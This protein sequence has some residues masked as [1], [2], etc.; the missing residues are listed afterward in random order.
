MRKRIIFVIFA[1]SLPVLGFT[2]GAVGHRTIAYI[3]E[4]YLTA[5]T[6]QKI[7]AIL[8]KN[9]D[10]NLAYISTWADDVRN[11]P[12]YSDTGFWHFINLP[13]RKDITKNNVMRYCYYNNCIVSQINKE[14]NELKNKNTDKKTQYED[15]KFLVHFIGDLHMPLHCSNDSDSGGNKKIVRLYE[16]AEDSYGNTISLHA[17]W[18]CIIEY[19][20]I[21]NPRN[22]ASY[23]EKS[24]TPKN[25]EPWAYGTIEDWAFESY[26]IAKYKIYA[27]FP[28]AGAT[29]K[30]VSLNKN[31]YS[32][33]RP[34]A[35]EQIK[36]AGIR[37][38]KVLNEIFGR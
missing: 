20:P 4:D 7:N 36:K 32:R 27:D 5:K 6:K 8:V 21:E 31:Y 38:A 17:L 29:F 11:Q 19:E 30:E 3:A 35:E 22:F 26:L 15:L 2:W 12:E 1:L 37:M 28:N 13:I 33:M 25:K 14:I 10:S 34:I 16:P 23:L 18:D 9:G 24:I